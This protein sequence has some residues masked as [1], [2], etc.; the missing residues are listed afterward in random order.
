LDIKKIRQIVDIMK[1]AELSEFQLE[2]GDF[3]LRLQRSYSAPAPASV[4]PVAAPP[5]AAPSA[6]G[7]ASP[8]SKAADEGKLVTSP[9]VGTFY[10][11]PSPESP[12]FVK[13]G[14]AVTEDTVVCILEAMKVMNEIKAE[15]KGTIAE[16][17]VGNGDSV[18]Y[19]QPLFRLR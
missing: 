17:L 13:P 5:P 11:A 19:G 6:S 14:D 9:M 4:P 12:P 7:A 3:K 2:E 18:E 16:V 15:E 1:R 8:E 10:A